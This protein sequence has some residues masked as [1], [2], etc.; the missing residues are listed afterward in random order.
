LTASRIIDRSAVA[1]FYDSDSISNPMNS[2]FTLIPA[3]TIR[4]AAAVP[5]RPM[6]LLPGGNF[7]CSRD[8]TGLAADLSQM[9]TDA[10]AHGFY[11][12]GSGA[13][14]YDVY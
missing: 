5:N 12:A 9:K 7:R 14:G 6:F 11:R 4:A 13:L 8:F 3:L 1:T 2:E 10:T